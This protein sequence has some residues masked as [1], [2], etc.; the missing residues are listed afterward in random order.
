MRCRHCRRARVCRPRGLCWQC[1]Y[2]PAIRELYP[3]NAKYTIQGFGLN[4]QDAKLPS[5]P[6][7][8]LPGSPEKIAVMQQ[9]ARLGQELFHPLDVIHSQEAERTLSRVG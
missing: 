5:R 7:Q 8:A 1:F 3:A 2:T 4:V 9:R 6:T